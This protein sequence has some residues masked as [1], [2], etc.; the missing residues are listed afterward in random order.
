MPS[1]RNITFPGIAPVRADTPLKLNGRAVL[2]ASIQ[3]LVF[4][5]L[6]PEAAAQDPTLDAG[7]VEAIGREMYGCYLASD[8]P[9]AL[10]LAELTAIRGLYPDPGA[11]RA[12]HQAFLA[13]AQAGFYDPVRGTDAWRGLVGRWTEDARR[14]WDEPWFADQQLAVTLATWDLDPPH[15][16]AAK[17]TRTKKLQSLIAGAYGK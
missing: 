8:F 9:E 16:D 15:D 13:R 7:N 3:A 11:L 1:F 2:A 14:P 5:F 6:V 10:V 4:L 12:A 17:E